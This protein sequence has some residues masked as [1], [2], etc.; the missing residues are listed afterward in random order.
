MRSSEA[1]SC[2]WRTLAAWDRKLDAIEAKLLPA[3]STPSRRTSLGYAFSSIIIIHITT[4]TTT[5][6]TIII[7]IIIIINF[8][9]EKKMYIISIITTTVIIFIITCGFRVTIAL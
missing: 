5:T 1:L 8:F 3:T 6:V 9:V 7:I 2:P 4:T